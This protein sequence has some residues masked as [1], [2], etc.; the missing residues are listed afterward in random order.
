M[1]FLKHSVQVNHTYFWRN[2]FY[3]FSL[4]RIGKSTNENCGLNSSNYTLETTTLNNHKL[5]RH[6]QQ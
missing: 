3:V 2:R 1:F 4:R 5:K 6:V